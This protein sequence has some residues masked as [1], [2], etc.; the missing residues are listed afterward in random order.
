M[1]NI[2]P[3]GTRAGYRRRL[4]PSDFAKV[5]DD[6]EASLRS[7]RTEGP[8]LLDRARTSRRTLPSDGFPRSVRPLV[9]SGGG[10]HSSPVEAA[11]IPDEREDPLWALT[12]DMCEAV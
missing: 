9:G 8:L 11:V 5:L 10:G 2:A 1:T 6:A 3:I 12:V 7:L 4:S